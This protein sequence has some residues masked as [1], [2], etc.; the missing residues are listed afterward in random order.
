MPVAWPA[1]LKAHNYLTD[2]CS[3]EDF[4]VMPAAAYWNLLHPT[5]SAKFP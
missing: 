2:R 3:A 5:S 1:W 4:S